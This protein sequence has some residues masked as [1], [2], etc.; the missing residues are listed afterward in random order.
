MYLPF[1]YYCFKRKPMFE[2][3]IERVIDF[4]EYSRKNGMSEIMISKMYIDLFQ[5]ILS[6]TVQNSDENLK[7]HLDTIKMKS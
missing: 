1:I 2:E 7:H 6:T 5:A 4:I 3:R